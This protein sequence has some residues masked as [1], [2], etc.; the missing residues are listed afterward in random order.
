MESVGAPIA[1]TRAKARSAMPK[2]AGRKVFIA[3]K[4]IPEST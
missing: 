2:T 1:E 4:I 3:P